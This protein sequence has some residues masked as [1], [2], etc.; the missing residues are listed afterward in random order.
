MC[1]SVY[2]FFSVLNAKPLCL[3]G[4]NVCVFKRVGCVAGKEAA[5]KALWL[6]DSWFRVCR[7]V[8]CCLSAGC[9]VF[10]GYS[11]LSMVSNGPLSWLW[12]TPLNPELRKSRRIQ[13]TSPAPAECC[14]WWWC[15]QIVSCCWFKCLNYTCKCNYWF[16]FSLYVVLSIVTHSFNTDT[17]ITLFMSISL[18]NVNIFF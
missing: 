9:W 4:M 16:M 3:S 14:C 15:V 6:M 12:L 5:T 8:Y 11:L 17:K 2:T 1:V 10:T 13:F 18:R 7:K